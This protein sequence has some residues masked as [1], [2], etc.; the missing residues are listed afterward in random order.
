MAQAEM[1]KWSRGQ[2]TRELTRVFRRAGFERRGDEWILQTAELHWWI[3][4]ATAKYDVHEHELA[5][6]SLLMRDGQPDYDAISP[7]NF[8]LDD[9]PGASRRAY[10]DTDEASE[11][12]MILD[13]ETLLIP[14]IRRLDSVESVVEMWLAG[15]VK[16]GS[17][18]TSRPWQ[19]R[20][21]WKLAT[22]TANHTL[23]DRALRLAQ[24]TRWTPEAR[25]LL[26][27]AGMPL[28]G[29]VRESPR[30]W[31]LDGVVQRWYFRRFSP[32]TDEVRMPL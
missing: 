20:H 28:E 8:S 19:L 13:V 23:A 15:D 10:R 7:A 11:D 27:Q 9:L 29:P 4:L 18:L 17:V 14:L 6:G 30:Y 26:V 22:V 3:F 16:A 2:R 1:K 12:P 32:I 5:I 21:A 24:I 31:P 25:S